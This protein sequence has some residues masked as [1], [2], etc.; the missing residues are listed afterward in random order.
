MVTLNKQ[1]HQNCTPRR[2]AGGKHGAALA[3]ANHPVSAPSGPLF[4]RLLNRFRHLFRRIVCDTF[5]GDVA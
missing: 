4:V 1:S 5:G 2:V 3:G